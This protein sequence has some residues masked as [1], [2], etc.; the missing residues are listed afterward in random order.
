MKSVIECSALTEIVS[1][2]PSL[3]DS[4]GNAGMRNSRL[5]RPPV[6]VRGRPGYDLRKPQ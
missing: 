6:Y 4:T 3:P 5:V 2:R 1:A